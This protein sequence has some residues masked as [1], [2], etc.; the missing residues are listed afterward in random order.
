[1]VVYSS[2]KTE[3]SGLQVNLKIE[4]QNFYKANFIPEAGTAFFYNPSLDTVNENVPRLQPDAVKV[5]PRKID[6][7]ITSSTLGLV[8]DRLVPAQELSKV[9]LLQMVILKM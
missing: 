7:G 6:V 9:H 5:Y 8:V 1:M 4:V 3:L 2:L